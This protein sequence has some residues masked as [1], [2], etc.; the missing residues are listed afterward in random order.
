MAKSERFTGENSIFACRL[1]K[2]M[3]NQGITQLQL[4]KELNMTRQAVSLYLTGQALPAIDKLLIICEYF[5]V[6][7]DYLLGITENP[8][9]DT[10]KQFITDYTK[11]SAES[12]EQLHELNIQNSNI[13]NYLLSND[14][15]TS[16]MDLLQKSKLSSQSSEWL[17]SELYSILITIPN[18][19]EQYYNLFYSYR[20]KNGF[21]NFKKLIGDE[22]HE[23]I[24]NTAR[25]A[26][27]KSTIEKNN[28]QSTFFTCQTIIDIVLLIDLH[29]NEMTE[30]YFYSATKKLD[31]ILSDYCFDFSQIDELKEEITQMI[32]QPKTKKKRTTT[33]HAEPYYDD[34]FS[35][36]W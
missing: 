24:E 12:I 2:M 23:K 13:I 4:A 8:T 33:T 10:N 1:K 7:S 16:V 22:L 18:F 31:D 6:S 25:Q 17:L 19:K 5:N 11:L 26:I 29:L 15:L 20:D 35:I 27:E 9:R 14:M 28:F 32:W 36:E 21:E 34:K 3:N 30:Y